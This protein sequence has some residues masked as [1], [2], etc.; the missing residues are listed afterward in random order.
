MYCVAIDLW[1]K[2]GREAE[3]AALF[4]EYVPIVEAMPGTIRFKVHR[5]V[6]DPSHFLLYEL[7]D[8]REALIAHRGDELF[9]VWRPRIAALELRRHLVEYN[10]VVGQP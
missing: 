2:A 8:S 4:Q 1:A 7:Y 6:A 9:K 10:T 5:D 3:V